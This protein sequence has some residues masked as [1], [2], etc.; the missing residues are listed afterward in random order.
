MPDEVPDYVK[1]EELDK[2][3]ARRQRDWFKLRKLTVNRLREGLSQAG[4]ARLYG[5]SAGFVNQWWH[6]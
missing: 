6:R 1:V 2:R 4:V 3:E 5:V